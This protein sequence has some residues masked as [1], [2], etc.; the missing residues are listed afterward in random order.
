M[1]KSFVAVVVALV[2]VIFLATSANAQQSPKDQNDSQWAPSVGVMIGQ[3]DS[4]SPDFM[5]TVLEEVTG[6]ENVALKGRSF[7]VC[8][9]RGRSGHS[10]FRIC[11][12]RIAI[13]DGST[14]SDDYEDVVTS[15]VSVKGPRVEYLWRL[16]PD[17]WRIAPVFA[18][19]GGVGKVSGKMHVTEYYVRY[20]TV[21]MNYTI[22][23]TSVRLQSDRPAS[24]YLKLFG[25]DWTVIGGANVGFTADINSHLTLTVGVY[26]LEI[27]QGSYK[28]LF[29][30]T[31][32]PR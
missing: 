10:Y 21:G 5:N 27:Q 15:G 12:S 16:G 7:D 4:T 11:Y 25:E 26:G 30:V 8:A 19:N 31:Y 32:W 2:A 14:L 18:L 20:S 29:Q 1:R 17:S 6:Y 24:V 9:A 28:G 13:R 23:R 3:F 22:T